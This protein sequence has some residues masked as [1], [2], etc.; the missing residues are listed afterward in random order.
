MNKNQDKGS[1]TVS[2]EPEIIIEGTDQTDIG[3]LSY[4]LQQ[5]RAAFQNTPSNRARAYVSILIFAYNNLQQHTKFCIESILKYTEN[6]DYELVLLDNGSS[7]GTFE[8]FKTV[9][10]APK[11]IVRITENKGANYGQFT[12]TKYLTGRYVAMIANDVYVTPNWLSNMLKCAESDERIGFL[13]TFSDNISNLQA[14]NLSFDSLD[15]MRLKAEQYNVSDPRKWEER[16]RL[17]PA[18]ALYKRECLDII[19]SLDYAFRHDFSDDDISFRVR[20]AGYKLICCGDV[21]VHH[22]GSS[23]AGTSEKKLEVLKRGREIFKEKY[24]G[25]DAWDDINNFELLMLNL[26]NPEE[27]RGKSNPRVLGIDVKCG[28]PILQLKNKLRLA[29]IFD[30]ELS[31]FVQDPKYWLDLK[32]ICEGKV[33]VDRIEYISEHFSPARFDYILLGNPLNLYPQGEEILRNLL[34]LLKRE[35]QLLIK[36][37]NHFDPQVFFKSKGKDHASDYKGV[38][39][40]DIDHMNQVLVQNGFAIKDIRLALHPLDDATKE[41]VRDVI[42]QTYADDKVEATF[43]E[44]T[45]EEYVIE[46]FNTGHAQPEE[47][48]DNR[49]ELPRQ[50]ETTLA[51]DDPLCC[52]FLHAT[53]A[54]GMTSIIMFTH[55]HLE[56]TQKCLENLRKFTPESHEV[57][58]VDDASADGTVKW[59]Q[60]QVKN[61][62]HYDII[63]NKEEGGY[64]LRINQGIQRAQGEYILLLNYNAVV[65]PGWLEGML[66]CLKHA[67]DA[68][69]IGP[70]TDEANGIQQISNAISCSA[71]CL[72]S[73]A[74][75]FREKHL[76]RRIP[77]RNLSSFCLLFTRQFVEKIGLL[78]GQFIIADNAIEDYCLRAVLKGHTNYI[79]G[80]VLILNRDEEKKPSQRRE[81]E[82]KWALTTSSVEG[83]DLWVLKARKLAADLQM[84]GKTDQAIEALI[85]CIKIIPDHVLIYYEMIRIFLELKKFSEAWEVVTS[86]PAHAKDALKGLEYAGYI[87]E[88]LD[89]NDDAA[90][91]AE[92]MT[93]MDAYYAPALNLK[94]VLAY[95][96][97]EEDQ[98][99]EYFK[100]AM[101][102]DPGYGEAYTN[103]GV[104]YWRAGEAEETLAHLRKGFNLS[105]TVPDT[106]ALYYSVVSAMS[107]FNDAEADFVEACSVSPHN[108]HL[109]FLYI[110]VLLQQGKWH[111]AMIRIEDA[112]SS[113]GLDEGMLKAALDIREKIGP[114][115]IDETARPNTLSLCMIVKNEEQNLVR[116]LHSVRDIADEIIIVDTGSTDRTIDIAKVFGAQVFTFPWTG[117]FS[118]ARNYSLKQATGDWILVLDA[119]EVISA[120]DLKEMKMLLSKASPVPVAYSIATRNYIKK[121]S[122]TGWERNRGEYPEEAGAGWVRSDKVRLFPRFADIRFAG[123]VHEMVE[124]SLKKANIRICPST[125]VIHHYGKL[126]MERE[127]QK[128]EMYYLLGKM[129]YES[130]PINV[131]YINE[132]AKQAHWLNKYD[133]AIDLWTK[134]LAILENDPQS[135]AYRQ[136]AKVS[137]GEAIAE[138][139]TQIA[140][141]YLMSGRYREALQAASKANQR[142]EKRNEHILMYAHC[143]VISGSLNAAVSAV[144]EI[145]KADP[146]QPPA[147]FLKAVILHLEEINEQSMSIFRFLL[148]SRI[149]LTPVLNSIIRQLN[150]HGKR[151]EALSLLNLEF[152]FGI[153]DE[154]TQT[155]KDL[156][157]V[158]QC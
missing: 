93:A 50:K 151:K 146:N 17:M 35:G 120:R 42:R 3:P 143:E 141:V 57:I 116:C 131:K 5:T 124:E 22:E 98:A 41:A 19:G 82:K 144:E 49:A 111:A 92:R 59:L 63:E 34:P 89:L 69:I 80:D 67:P 65:G 20:R 78:D 26:V 25:V 81:I 130:D 44:L 23:A 64:A 7:D 74:L 158:K 87:K 108:K 29:D 90:V 156:L 31:A 62:E 150:D 115:R 76:N 21:F 105:P 53:V 84:Q 56:D 33:V 117:D 122:V 137:Y 157:A 155:L 2:M 45:A 75:I 102:S 70:V 77:S 153:Q 103:L 118:E 37:K 16:L 132:L 71:E 147:L 96:K 127:T 95:K 12:A 133:E 18:I 46:I 52:C 112:L 10:H 99:A 94:G 101:V 43:R 40:S 86:M 88:G 100:K 149:H 83:R 1:H 85:D 11:K 97:T 134:L 126:D 113:F 125:I 15:E 60:A 13:A 68:G 104:L 145:L 66:A 106:G 91:Y 47:L 36:L 129:K 138:I 136:I 114:Q 135:D 24:F 30:T 154:E 14:V 58:F 123:P 8:Y 27:M 54:Q 61:N 140:A 110:D 38:S 139:Y 9:P 4:S 119:D 6:I 121:I 48:N 55:D 39:Y 107:R 109:A 152:T 32:T 148:D 73:D 28:T 142:K 128:Y 72:D 79:A 51:T